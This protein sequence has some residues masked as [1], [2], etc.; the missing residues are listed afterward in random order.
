MSDREDLGVVVIGRNEGIRLERCLHSLSRVHARIVYVDS[1]STDGSVAL[2]EAMGATVVALD[3][4]RKFTAARAR[5][6]GF[7]ELSSSG[8]TPKY[9]QFVDGDCEMDPGWLP[10]ATSYLDEH[11]HTVAV[12]GRRRER[13]PERS[14]Y[15]RLC[16]LEWDKPVGPTLSVGGD[17]LIRSEAFAEVGG[18]NEDLIAGEEPEMCFRLRRLGWKIVVLEAEMT[19][20]D[21]ALLRF[22]QW[23]QRMVRSGHAYAEGMFLH[24]RSPERFWVRESMRSWVWVTV[25][26]LATVFSCAT[27]GV[28]GLLVLLL[29]P[30]QVVRQYF[31]TGGTVRDRWQTAAFN[32]LARFP[33][34]VGQLQFLLNRVL[35]GESQLIEYK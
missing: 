17:F 12:C 27:Y 34:F 4:S 14:I 3:L 33:E 11:P 10:L 1:G 21:A 16:D 22:S 20:H 5:N 2:A 29:Y 18:I 6:A 23:W 28:A 30:A 8:T 31:R 32:Q 9:V 19:K 13:Y 35:R 15:N 25:P 24:G 7:R 26:I